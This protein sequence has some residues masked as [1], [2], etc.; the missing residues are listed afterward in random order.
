M[1]WHKPPLELL[2]EVE[3]HLNRGKLGMA[4]STAKSLV[5]ELA[6]NKNQPLAKLLSRHI[7]KG[8]V[9]MAFQIIDELHFK[10]GEKK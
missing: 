3:G 7:E 8:L 10:L 2:A 5:V 4:R 6:R 9:V 1:L